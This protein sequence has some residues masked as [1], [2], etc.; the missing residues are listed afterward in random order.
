MDN[1]TDLKKLW[2]SADTGNLPRTSEMMHAISKYR[3]SK[4]IKKT[5]LIVAAILLTAVMVAV[6]FNY[7][8][9]MVSTRVGEVLIIAA[10]I[11][12][13]VGNIRSIGRLYRVK[14]HTNKEFIEYLG[15]V[16]RNRIYYHKKTQVVGLLLTSIGLLLYIYEG[17]YKNL[18][19]CIAA[20]AFIVAYIAVAW[21]IIRPRAYKRQA[22]KLEETIKKMESIAKQF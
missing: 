1:L 13:V 22:K 7:K 21:F 5:A 15:Q 12:L 9:V 11:M 3:S 20:Y 14:D 10:G 8:S 16:Q 17:V 6:V 18:V 19:L 4:L 2:L